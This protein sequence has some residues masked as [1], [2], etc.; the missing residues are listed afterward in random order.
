M[1]QEPNLHPCPFCGCD[2]IEYVPEAP[3]FSAGDCAA[4][5]C[6]NLKEC[7]A[8]MYQ[9]TTKDLVKAWNHRKAP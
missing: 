1:S 6:G 7:G 5:V 2:R 4:A 8:R 3:P 9:E